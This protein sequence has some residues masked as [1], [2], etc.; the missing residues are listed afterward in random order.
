MT[1]HHSKH[2]KIMT[3]Y[4]IELIC[5]TQWTPKNVVVAM[6]SLV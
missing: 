3:I 5:A 1:A 2:K 6:L 4:T